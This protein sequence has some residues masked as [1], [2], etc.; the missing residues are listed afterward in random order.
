MG[1]TC[2]GGFCRLPISLNNGRVRLVLG[3]GGTNGRLEVFADGGWGQVCDDRFDLDD[4]GPRVVCREL[5]FASGS[6]S[7]ATGPDDVFL[8]DEVVCAGNEA[9]LID[10][11]H[12]PLGDEDCN[13]AD[14]VFISCQ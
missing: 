14:A 4:H 9:T 10:C 12:N 13:A 3:D 7:D 8:I 6:Q 2:S 1:Q 5:G 11:A